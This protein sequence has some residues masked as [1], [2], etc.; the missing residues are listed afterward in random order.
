CL[1]AGKTPYGRNPETDRAYNA[2][3]FETNK[4]QFSKRNP[5]P[6][7]HFFMVPIALYS[8]G[9]SSRMKPSLLARYLTFLRLANYYSSCEFS[10]DL[11]SLEE[12]DGVS[13]RA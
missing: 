5:F 8:S 3:T 9:L 6:G 12:L 1:R 2:M 4:R 13:T 11:K 10:I 7:E